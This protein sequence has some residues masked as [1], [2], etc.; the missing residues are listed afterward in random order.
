MLKLCALDCRISN[1]GFIKSLDG[2]F[3]LKI[4]F[5]SKKHKNKSVRKG[6]NRV[7]VSFRHQIPACPVNLL[8]IYSINRMV[9]V[10]FKGKE[11]F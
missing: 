6:F 4:L 1:T 9:N 3:F 11:P 2:G 10:A 8:S 7:F 5:K